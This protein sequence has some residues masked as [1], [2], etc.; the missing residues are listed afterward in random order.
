MDL[1]QRAYRDGGG[2]QLYYLFP[3]SNGIMCSSD[4]LE[5]DNCEL[6]GWSNGAVS[7]NDG[8]NQRVHHNHIHHNQ[9]HGLGYGVVIDR[10]FATI[11]YNL[12][13]YC[14]HHIAGTGRPSGYE[15]ANNVALGHA[16][17]HLF[18]MHGGR[19]R[20]DGTVIAGTWMKVHHNTF[21]NPDQRAVVIRGVPQEKAEVDHNWFQTETADDKTLVSDGST[22]A[23]DNVYGLEPKKLE[24]VYSFE[25]QVESK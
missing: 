14:R 2:A 23:Q 25:K 9:H 22:Y 20:K 18:D 6:F 7:L 19:D 10:A 16:N 15:A 24:E 11:D 4:A 21:W 1:H 3:K 8:K 17:S 13:D 12:F 5:V